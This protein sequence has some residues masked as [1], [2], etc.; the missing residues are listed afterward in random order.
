LDQVL[1]NN[2][3]LRAKL[4]TYALPERMYIKVPIKANGITPNDYGLQSFFLCF[5]SLA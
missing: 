1:E 5:P 4:S 2:D 3:E